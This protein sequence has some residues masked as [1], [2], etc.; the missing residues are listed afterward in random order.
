MLTNEPLL[1]SIEECKQWY[2]TLSNYRERLNALKT[3]LYAFAPGKTDKEVLLGI[4]HFHN[5]F[6]I[7]LINVHDLQHEMKPFIM[8]YEK[9]PDQPMDF[10]YEDLKGKLDFLVNDLDQLD[11]DFHKFIG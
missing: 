7:Q 3:E 8:G 9:H 6:H 11:K 1:K 4:E 2:N 5:Q 10:P